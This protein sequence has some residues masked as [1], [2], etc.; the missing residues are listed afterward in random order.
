MSRRYTD[1]DIAEA[2]RAS[3]SIAQVLKRIGLTRPVP[4]MLPCTRIFQTRSEDVALHRTGTLR[5]T[6]CLAGEV[7]RPG[8]GPHQRQ[9]RGQSPRKPQG[10]LSQ[11]Q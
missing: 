3:F 6:S 9:P 7:S 8:P 11:L 2:V 5:A 1:Q 4:T 10:S